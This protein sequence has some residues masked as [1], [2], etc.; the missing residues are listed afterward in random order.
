V[1]ERFYSS[2]DGYPVGAGRTFIQSDARATRPALRAPTGQ[3]VSRASAHKPTS[4][5]GGQEPGQANG[6][7][8]VACGGLNGE[9]ID[10]IPRRNLLVASGGYSKPEYRPHRTPRSGQPK[11]AQHREAHQPEIDNSVLVRLCR[12]VNFHA[13]RL[14]TRGG[15][16]QIKPSARRMMTTPA[17]AIS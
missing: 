11:L 7:M 10:A 2:A 3:S 13:L 12:S 5:L 15:A 9:S 14:V 17:F 8:R 16:C 1:G 6:T 4:T